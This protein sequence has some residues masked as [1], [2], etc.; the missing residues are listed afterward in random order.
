MSSM[1]GVHRADLA[2]HVGAEVDQDV[3]VSALAERHEEAIAE[4]G[5]YIRMRM[6]LAIDQIPPMDAAEAGIAAASNG[7][8]RSQREAGSPAVA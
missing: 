7:D 1:I 3:V 5:R 8:V 4:P 6:S 2:V